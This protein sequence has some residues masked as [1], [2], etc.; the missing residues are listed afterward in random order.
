MTPFK[1][2]TSITAIVFGMALAISANGEGV[3]LDG[4][5]TLDAKASDDMNKV[6]EAYIANANFVVRSV[7]RGKFKVRHPAYKQVQIAHTATEVV[8]TFDAENPMVLPVDGKTAQ[9][10]R[11]DGEMLGMKGQWQSNHLIQIITHDAWKRTNDFQ[12]DTEGNTLTLSVDFFQQGGVN[13]KPMLYHLV[14]RRN[15]LK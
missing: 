14:Y 12:L 5:Y 1:S 11:E 10:K 7:A 9:W 3:A 13:D 4:S 2:L 6:I 15:G 8:V